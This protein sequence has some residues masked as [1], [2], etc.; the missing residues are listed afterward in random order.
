MTKTWITNHIKCGEKRRCWSLRPSRKAA[1]TYMYIYIGCS[2]RG[3]LALG[4][5]RES[6]SANPGGSRDGRPCQYP[7]E[8]ISALST[9]NES[10]GEPGRNA[11]QR[12]SERVTRRSGERPRRQEDRYYSVQ[13]VDLYTHNFAYLGTR[14]TGNRGS[15][16][17]KENGS[18][19]IVAAV[20]TAV[21]L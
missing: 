5:I 21:V 10:S 14:C 9:P 3:N 7:T 4:T 20:A 13:L 19:I 16:D 12:A 2:E 17:Q 18:W 6:L 11:F 8:P 15:S 1:Y